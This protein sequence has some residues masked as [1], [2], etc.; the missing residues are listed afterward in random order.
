MVIKL[1]E[2]EEESRIVLYINP[3]EEN[4]QMTGL[5]K[6][7]L[8]ENI[9]LIELDYSEAHRLVFDSVKVDMEYCD[10]KGT[11]FIWHKVRIINHKG[12]YIMQVFANG[13]K[14]NR[15]GCF[16]VGVGIMANVRMLG[17]NGP[18]QVMVRDVS[19]SG[20]SVTDRR[21]ELNLNIG[22]KLTVRF[23]DLGYRLDLTGVVVRIEQHEDITVFGFKTCNLC[24]DLS[25]Y[26]SVK[27]RRKN[28]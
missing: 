25:T 20:F 11:P 8:K 19:L 26:V 23:D 6:K 12:Q 22:D 17:N 24:K 28:N 18:A 4:M 16:R 15:R 13:A 10:E 9:A 7:H 27:Q 2:I 14:H 1:E 5:L 21:G 3:D